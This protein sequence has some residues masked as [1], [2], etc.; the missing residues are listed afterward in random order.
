MKKKIISIGTIAATCVASPIFA[1]SN[2]S[3][4][5]ASQGAVVAAQAATNALTVLN[6]NFTPP[7][8]APPIVPVVPVITTLPPVQLPGGFTVTTSVQPPVNGVSTSTAVTTNNINNTTVSTTVTTTAPTPS[9]GTTTTAI[10]TD[11]NGAT[12][13]T[14]TVR[15]ATGNVLSTETN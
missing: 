12:T 4:N 10:T 15:D 9:G 7:V 1:V 5:T 2:F 6:F 13:T 14:T 11:V 8:V 3:D